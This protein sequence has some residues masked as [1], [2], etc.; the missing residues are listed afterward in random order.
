MDGARFA[1]ASAGSATPPLDATLKLRQGACYLFSLSAVAPPPSPTAGGGG[2]SASSP[3]T[4]SKLPPQQQ[5]Q[6]SPHALA[7]PV[8]EGAHVAVWTRCARPVQQ[9]QPGGGSMVERCCGCCFGGGGGADGRPA[10]AADEG[11]ALVGTGPAFPGDSSGG[12][13]AGGDW[14]GG[15]AV[16][17]VD[18][19]AAAGGN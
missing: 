11:V 10:V 4:G 5:H 15:A 3:R 12:G 2:G 16:A 14:K 18:K 9:Q 8:L 7:A 17:V 1:L 19:G 13:G 6:Q